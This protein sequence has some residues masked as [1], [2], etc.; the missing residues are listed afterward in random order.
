M[1]QAF[2]YTI[3]ML[4]VYPVIAQDIK[5]E[6]LKDFGKVNQAYKEHPKLRFKMSYELISDSE[7]VA[8]KHHTEG[9]TII[10]GTKRYQR[11]EDLETFNH[12]YYFLAVNK[13]EK[14]ISISSQNIKN[15]YE[16]GSDWAN[17]VV[18]LLDLCDSITVTQKEKGEQTY[19]FYLSFG[20]YNR[21]AITFNER[22]YFIT[23][24]QMDSDMNKAYLHATFSEF[25]TRQIPNDDW[26]SF[27]RFLEIKDNKL[28]TKPEYQQYRLFN[29]VLDIN[30]LR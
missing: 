17:R 18:E 12:D 9:F 2:I 29:Q 16:V 30:A 3:L 19:M 14:T 25:S 8:I 1:K 22:S 21:I 11:I 10:A 20:V 23:G 5:Q 13:D 15:V 24:I 7:G 28:L 6:A 27:H 4:L 26:F